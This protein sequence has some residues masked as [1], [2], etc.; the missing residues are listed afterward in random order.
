MPARKDRINY[1]LRLSPEEHRK[2]FALAKR[3]GITFHQL[4][5]DGLGIQLD[6]DEFVSRNAERR[7][8]TISDHVRATEEEIPF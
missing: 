5:M 7:S 6:A 2:F 3:K 4:V 8:V 1:P